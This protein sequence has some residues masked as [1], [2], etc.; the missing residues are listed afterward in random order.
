MV[1]SFCSRAL[2]YHSYQFFDSVP[3]FTSFC[4]LFICLLAPSRR[5]T[6]SAVT[7]AIDKCATICYTSEGL[8]KNH[9][10]VPTQVGTCLTFDLCSVTDDGVFRTAKTRRPIHNNVFVS[11]IPVAV[12]MHCDTTSTRG[13]VGLIIVCRSSLSCWRPV[14]CSN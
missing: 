8:N 1:S 13:S 9:V 14:R 2:L 7:T 12:C 5:L 3:T 4:C 11:C 6:S 10:A